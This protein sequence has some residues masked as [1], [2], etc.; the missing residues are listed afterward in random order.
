MDKWRCQVCS[1][2][3]DEENGDPENG[4]SPK[5][6]FSELPDDWKCPVCGVGKDEFAKVT[7]DGEAGEEE[8]EEIIRHYSNEHLTIIWRPSRCNHNG[9]CTRRLPKV[10]DPDRRPWVDI[11]QASPDLIKEV[12]DECPTQ[13][14]T[15][16]LPKE[17]G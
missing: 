2:V 14:L 7:G 9:N 5:K 3:F 15:Y 8:S 12:V 11:S 1:Y 10:F 16:Q 6:P 17:E 4:I 13:A